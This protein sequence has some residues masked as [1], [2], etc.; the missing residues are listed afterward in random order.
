MIE[1]MHVPLA[2]LVACDANMR[3]TARESGLEELASS[4]QAHGLL[5]NLTVRP[6]LDGDGRE[7]GKHEV[8]AGGRRLAALRLL[9]KRKV[10][11]KTAPV[12]CAPLGG[13]AAIE[14]SLAENSYVPPHPADQYEAFRRLHVEEGLPA[15][16]IAARFG[17]SERTVRQRLRLAAVSPAL[18]QQYR[19]GLLNLEQLMAFA[20]TDDHDRQEQVWAGLGWNRGGEMIRRVL[21][22]AHVPASDRRAVLVG[23]ERYEAAGGTVVRDLFSEDERGVYLE[24]AA[25]LDRLVQERL[26][27]EGETVRAEGWRWIAV[28]PE[29]AY[30]M[31]AGLRRV[32]PRPR[33][34]GD[35]QQ[36]RLDALEQELEALSLRHDGGEAT[37]EVAA[38]IERLEAEIEAL[39]GREAYD[40]D[41]VARAGALVC[42][43]HD[44]TVRIER[45][46]VRP[47]DE[48]RPGPEASEGMGERWPGAAEAAAEEP[49]DS[50]PGE[51]TF[52][53]AAE[54]EDGPRAL[55]ERLVEEL[56]THRTAGLQAALMDSPD[57]ALIAT[58]HALALRVLYAPHDG[59]PCSL[60]IE[61]SPVALAFGVSDGPAARQVAE[62]QSAWAR[63]L[64]KRRDELWAWVAGQ[65]ADTLLRLLAFCAARTVDTVR[66][67]YQSH[68][69]RLAHADALAAAVRLDMAEHWAPTVESY[70]GRVTKAHILEAVREGASERDAE[71]SS[72]MKKP[73]MAAHAERLLAGRR[74]LPPVLRTPA[75]AT[76]SE[77]AV[78]ERGE[79]V[80]FAAE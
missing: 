32:Y 49:G 43:G 2:K 62:R 33:V 69:Q 37:P 31:A 80:A 79:P 46:F 11:A 57:V 5:Q 50:R 15:V 72:G 22:Q 76:E 9:A 63:R 61:A 75:D 42:L 74:W 40:P 25:L 27:A 58:V 38:E 70:L 21:T 17:V 16:E 13:T 60:R 34:L 68:P 35:E 56:T 55:P 78:V 24:D 71:G 47:E 28:H 67:P 36:T 29:F 23:M 1:I 8:V 51:G 4:I 66:S 41:E 65:E 53:A 10:I 52:E 44:G 7:T 18:V 30:G 26:E 59:P 19:E 39:L 64:P 20:I 3:R 77:P 14:V 45:G 54:E 73:E 48:P 12:P 6:A